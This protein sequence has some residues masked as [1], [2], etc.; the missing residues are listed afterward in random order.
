MIIEAKVKGWNI[1]RHGK[2]LKEIAESVGCDIDQLEVIREYTERDWILRDVPEEL[3]GTLSYMAYE[4]GH[5]G[6]DEEV[7]NILRT[8]VNDLLPSIL[9]YG[10]RMKQRG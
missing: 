8:L 9:K 10:D 6:G 5:S 3:K 7:I 4:R 1:T 2:S